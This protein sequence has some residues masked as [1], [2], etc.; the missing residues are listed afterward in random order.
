MAAQEISGGR[1]LFLAQDRRLNLFWRIVLYL[2]GVLLILVLSLLLVPPLLSIGAKGLPLIVRASLG[3]GLVLLINIPGVL[4]LTY[5]FRRHI[6]YRQ[7]KGMALTSLKKGWF[8]ALLGFG[9]GGLLLCLV[10]AIDYAFGWVQIVGTE[11]SVSGVAGS[12]VIA[13][14]SLFG[15]SFLPGFTEELAFRGY[16]F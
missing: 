5:F 16:V 14:L 10:F 13:L 9:L 12:I 15:G 1:R 2:I 3:N 11:F 4:G 7:W 8:Q 6:D